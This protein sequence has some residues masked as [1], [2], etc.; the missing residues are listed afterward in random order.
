MPNECNKKLHILNVQY[1][2]FIL[3][4]L[5][6]CESCYGKKKR[7]FCMAENVAATIGL[8]LFDVTFLNNHLMYHNE[9]NKISTSKNGP[10]PF[11]RR[12]NKILEQY[13]QSEE[14]L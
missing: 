12:S 4:F 6:K 14:L 2:N 13:R 9:S 8:K 5:H 10:F 7:E 11:E 3:H 1:A